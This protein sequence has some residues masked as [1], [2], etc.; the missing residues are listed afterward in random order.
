MARSESEHFKEIMAL[1]LSNVGLSGPPDPQHLGG[2]GASTPTAVIP[3]EQSHTLGPGTAKAADN[4]SFH[5]LMGLSRSYV[6]PLGPPASTH[7]EGSG[8]SAQEGSEMPPA[9]PALETAPVCGD[10]SRPV[11]APGGNPSIGDPADKIQQEMDAALAGP[12]IQTAGP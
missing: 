10:G 9:G 12:F 7:H 4:E 2:S 5:D 8:V 1:V 3:V 11:A 6:D